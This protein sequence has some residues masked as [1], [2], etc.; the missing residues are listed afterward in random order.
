MKRIIWLAPLLFFFCGLSAQPS[1]PGFVILNPRSV[2]NM[3]DL[4]YALG[5]NDLDKYRH[6]D[7]RTTIHFNAGLDVELL[8]GTE[9]V[10]AG[11]PVDMSKV[12]TT[13]IDRTRNSQ[14]SLHPSGRIIV[15]VTPLKKGL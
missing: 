1:A 15:T 8:S 12:N 2:P 6:V 4:V 9:M 14:F 11:L 5:H 7:H 10:E 3:S 13:E